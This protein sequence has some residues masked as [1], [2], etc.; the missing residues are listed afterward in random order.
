M[1]TD[2]PRI[3]ALR[4]V[5]AEPRQDGKRVVAAFNCD[6]PGLRLFGCSLIIRPDGEHVIAGPRG[7]KSQSGTQA[8]SITDPELRAEMTRLAVAAYRGMGQPT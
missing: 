5:E 1:P 2:K 7:P 8:A 3:I 6:V 4:L